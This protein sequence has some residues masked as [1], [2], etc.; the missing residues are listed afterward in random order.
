MTPG[1][2]RAAARDRT[3]LL[4]RS[5]AR[6]DWLTTVLPVAASQTGRLWAGVWRGPY[7]AVSVYQGICDPE[8]SRWRIVDTL[9]EVPPLDLDGRRLAVGWGG[10]SLEAAAEA[11]ALAAWWEMP[12]AIRYLGGSS[13]GTW[14]TVRV[15]RLGGTA[16]SARC[17]GR[18]WRRYRLDQVG[19]IGDIALSWGGD[20]YAPPE[21]AA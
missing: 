19:G 9:P 14:R 12:L 16:V 17:P 20:G 8:R 2:L 11:L 6:R 7:G 4:V 3:P 13:P 21:G 1:D 18:G 10:L 5:T 15:T